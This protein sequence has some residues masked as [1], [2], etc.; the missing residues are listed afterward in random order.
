MEDV[1]NNS[2]YFSGVSQ[3]LNYIVHWT[4]LVH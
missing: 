4:Y 3:S 1:I 2:K